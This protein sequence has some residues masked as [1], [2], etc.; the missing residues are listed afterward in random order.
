MN[1]M[2]LF[3]AIAGVLIGVL[4]MVGVVV[5]KRARRLEKRE[6]LIR[7]ASVAAADESGAALVA[8]LDA[9]AHE[10]DDCPVKV[11]WVFHNSA[12]NPVPSVL[13]T[14]TWDGNEWRRV[15]PI[16]VLY[17]NL[18]SVLSDGQ[19]HLARQFREDLQ[20]YAAAP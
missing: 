19:S 11:R 18:E 15:S 8:L 13:I 10:K 16:A 5:V 4:L 12:R 6:R 14:I 9:V 2:F 17:K 20:A 1:L 7:L 3:V